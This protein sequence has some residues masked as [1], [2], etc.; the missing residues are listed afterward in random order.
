M[1]R[2]SSLTARHYRILAVLWA[3]GILVAC[4]LPA[5]TLPEVQ[6]AFSPDKI[7]HVGLFAVFGILW[8]RGVCPP[9]DDVGT[10]CLVRHGVALLLVGG[11]FAAGTEVY[12]YLV[13]LQRLGDPFDA[14][15]NGIG[16]FLALGIY[17]GYHKQA[18]AHSEEAFT[19]P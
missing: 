9:N 7:V 12:Q 1:R 19:D 3:V 14:L 5:D 17:Y 13:P 4:S 10:S 15:A 6:S 18:S 2:L 11:L 16:L 8:M